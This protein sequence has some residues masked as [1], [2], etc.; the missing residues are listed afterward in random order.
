MSNT[1]KKEYEILKM[2]QMLQP[3]TWVLMNSRSITV[4]SLPTAGTIA[5]GLKMQN[6]HVTRLLRDYEKMGYVTMKKRIAAEVAEPDYNTTGKREN[7]TNGGKGRDYPVVYVYALT[8][9]GR[10]KL[11]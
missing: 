6:R 4:K 9:K 2:I 1:G 7:G 10:E 11:K 8:E 5:G 3:P